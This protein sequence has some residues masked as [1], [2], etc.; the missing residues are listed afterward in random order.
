[1]LSAIKTEEKY[2]NFAEIFNGLLTG[3]KFYSNAFKLLSCSCKEKD[4]SLEE[5]AE[6]F[7]INFEVLK[8]IDNIVQGMY[9]KFEAFK[10]PEENKNTEKNEET[11]QVS[12]MK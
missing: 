8:Q 2:G 11:S 10:D 6:A 7:S 5:I 3:D 9:T 1:M 12:N 4:W